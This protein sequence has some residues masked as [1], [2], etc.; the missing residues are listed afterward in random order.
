MY[1]GAPVAKKHKIAPYMVFSDQTLKEMSGKQP[2]TKA[3]MLAIKGVGEHKYEVYGEAF[4][5]EIH[6]G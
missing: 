5:D 2:A 6:G 3:S 1:L 4:L